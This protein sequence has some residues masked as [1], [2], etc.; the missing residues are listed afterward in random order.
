MLDNE[1]RTVETL[2]VTVNFH[3][4]LL[5]GWGFF[6]SKLYSETALKITVEF[7]KLMISLCFASCYCSSKNLSNIYS[8]LV[9][10]RTLIFFSYS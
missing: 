3:Y 9:L 1:L 8:K 7:C 10:K 5:Y 6:I 2:L 4:Q